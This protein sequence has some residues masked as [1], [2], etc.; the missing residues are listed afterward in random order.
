MNPVIKICGMR[1]YRNILELAELNPDILGFIFYSR[2]PRFAGE[3]LVPEILANLNPDIKKTG[4]FVNADL[5]VI[6]ETVQKYSLDI[7]QLHG[8][9]SPELCSRLRYAGITVIKAFNIKE[10]GDFSKCGE[11]INC[12]DYFLFDTFTENHGGSGQKFD[13]NILDKY[14]LGHPFFLSGGI[15]QNDIDSIAGITNPS[16]YGIDLNSRFEIT[17]GLKDIEKLKKFIHEFRLKYKSL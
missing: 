7:V 9:E 13:W 2:S 3:L 10:S 16:L 15:T 14:T 1:E 11:Y 12:T 17:P 5:T 6:S 4:V 8:I